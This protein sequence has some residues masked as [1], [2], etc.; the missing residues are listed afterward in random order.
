MNEINYFIEGEASLS[1]KSNAV[2]AL[3]S[4]VFIRTLDFSCKEFQIK[5][6]DTCIT[7]SK[8]HKDTV[9]GMMRDEG[10]HITAE[11]VLDF[12]EINFGAVQTLDP[13]TYA[14]QRFEVHLVEVK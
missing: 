8:V 11:S 10:V 1:I 14:S 4:K 7:I 2:P 6:V 3:N 9:H 13:I 5:R 12:I